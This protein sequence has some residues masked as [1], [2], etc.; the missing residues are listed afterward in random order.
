MNKAVILLPLL[1][2]SCSAGFLDQMGRVLADPSPIAPRVSSFVSEYC[3]DAE[4]GRGQG[5]GG[6]HSRTSG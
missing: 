1:L 6:I 5:S 4:L 2:V 3:I